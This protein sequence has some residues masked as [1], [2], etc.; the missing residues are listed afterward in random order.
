VV[1]Y[2]VKVRAV[3]YP[4]GP[5]QSARVGQEKGKLGGPTDEKEDARQVLTR[6]GG[7]CCWRCRG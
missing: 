1:R 4:D 7:V 5:R 3:W 6:Q 2:R